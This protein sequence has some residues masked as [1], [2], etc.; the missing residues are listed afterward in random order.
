VKKGYKDAFVVAFRGDERLQ[1]EEAKQ[2][3][4]KH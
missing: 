1:E 3:L 2:L 4:Q